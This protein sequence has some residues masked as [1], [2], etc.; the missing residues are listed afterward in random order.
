MELKLV[1]ADPGKFYFFKGLIDG[2]DY[3]LSHCIS[4]G[5]LYAGISSRQNGIE[6]KTAFQFKQPKLAQT[7]SSDGPMML[8]GI[9][10]YKITEAIS[11]GKMR[12]CHADYIPAVMED[13][14][15]SVT[16]EI[17]KH[18]KKL[19]LRTSQG[20]YSESTE[21][22]PSQ[23]NQGLCVHYRAGKVL[24]EFKIIYCTTVGLI[25]CGVL[26]RP[27]MWDLFILNNPTK[28]RN[29]SSN[30]ALQITPKTM[31]V[32]AVYKDGVMISPPIAWEYFDLSDL[33]EDES[34][35][36]GG[37]PA[38]VVESQCQLE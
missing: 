18:S 33:P 27:P 9:V 3:G 8:M 2:K 17:K 23:A 5:P 22:S 26:P 37:T 10:T 21:C 31:E 38:P 15:E 36:I 12:S 14:N 7:N 11:V 19:V 34:K 28:R 30:D 1:N 20:T 6:K 25:H 35:T 13:V 29:D 4:K 32:K 24:E 16:S